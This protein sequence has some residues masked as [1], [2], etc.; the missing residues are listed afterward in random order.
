MFNSNKY[1]SKVEEFSQKSTK[2]NNLMHIALAF[3]DN[4]AMPAGITIT[5]IIQNN[6]NL[7]FCF[8]LF[9]DTISSMQLQKFNE[10]VSDKC[11][12]KIYYL[13]NNFQVN[14]ET[15]LLG[16]LSF[17][18]CVRFIIPDILEKET[19]KFLYIDSDILCLKP[20][21]TLYN[22]EITSYIAAVIPDD[23]VMRNVIKDLYP[24][25]SEKYFNA[26]VLLIN[27]K[28]WVKNEISAKC[29]QTINDGNIY[30]FADQDVLNILLEGKTLLLPI[31]FNTKVQITISCREEKSIPPYTVLLHYVTGY[32]PWYQTFDSNL[33]KKYFNLSPWRHTR[34]PLALKR[35]WLR[36]FAKYN[37]KKGK[38]ATALKFYYLYLTKKNF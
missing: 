35:S 19:D 34:R 11:T 17:M 3:D 13:N 18:S 26:G 37:F 1:I 22:T 15:L 10:L 16:Y 6:N 30:R 23:D 2:D 27:T 14:S 33:F 12:I 28:E 21:N 8:H 29:M 9:V 7:N 36:H 38:I 25:N 5:S 4:Y 20:I 32:K 31:K 24:I